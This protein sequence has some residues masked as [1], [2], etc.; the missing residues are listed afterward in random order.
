MSDNIVTAA[1]LIIGDEILSGRTHDQ[2]TPYIALKL[3]EIGVHLREIRVVGDRESEIIEAANAL[4]KKYTYVFTTGGIGPTHDD[5]TTHSLAKG[6]KLKVER[7]PQALS[8]LQTHYAP[9]Q[10]N[11]ARLKM[12]D[13]PQG[14]ELIENP[15]SKAP[16]WRFEN[17]FVMAGVPKIM[18][19]MLDFVL[20]LLKGG[21]KIHTRTLSTLKREGDIAHLLEENIKTYPGVQIGSYPYFRDGGFGVSL[22]LKSVDKD[23]LEKATQN[24]TRLLEGV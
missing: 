24:L 14:A 12:A 17:V 2:N 6:L 22:V 7:N 11:E 3:G 10:L 4:R 21:A 15:V 16:G 8:M 13:I 1:L 23:Q 19:A 9:D 18:Q 20:P 5:I